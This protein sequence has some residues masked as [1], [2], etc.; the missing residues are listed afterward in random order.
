MIVVRAPDGA[1]KQEM[2]V[3]AAEIDDQGRRPAE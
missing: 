3:A 2:P 1:A